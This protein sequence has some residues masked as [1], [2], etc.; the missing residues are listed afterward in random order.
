MKATK[1][2]GPKYLENF[3]KDFGFY[4]TVTFSEFKEWYR[5]YGPRELLNLKSGD[6]APVIHAKS[7][8]LN[9]I[10]SKTGVIRE[11]YINTI[12]KKYLKEKNNILIIYGAGHLVKSRK[13]YE[14]FFGPSEN[15]KLY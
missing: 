14:D 9:I 10:S 7:T 3:S 6:M 11:E 2:Q 1:D 13:V 15:K 5:K 12:L 4:K 8:K